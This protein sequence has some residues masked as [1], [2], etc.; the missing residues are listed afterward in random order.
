MPFAL[1]RARR[2][3]SLASSLS[4]SHPLS[5]AHTPRLPSRPPP[6]VLFAAWLPVQRL[7]G[8]QFG[9]RTGTAGHP[10]GELSGWGLRERP[11]MSLCICPAALTRRGGPGPGCRPA[12]AG[13]SPPSEP[14]GGV[15]R[16][17]QGTWAGK[18]G[19][20]HV[21]VST[22]QTSCDHCHS[23]ATLA[24][25]LL[26]PGGGS[27]SFF[28]RGEQYVHSESASWTQFR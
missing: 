28:L 21:V 19:S 7:P 13:G 17:V 26:I 18:R 3:P 8:Q 23:T 11:W 1:P 2:P 5:A 22:G 6:R 16:A 24:L 4:K 10:Q 15:G 12:A 25:P 20:R 9:S 27:G 14:Q